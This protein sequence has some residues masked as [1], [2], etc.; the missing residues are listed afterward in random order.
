VCV[1]VCVC[2]AAATAAAAA[3]SDT[4]AINPFRAV[5]VP[6]VA[7]VDVLMDRATNAAWLLGERR[8]TTG[9][10]FGRTAEF[11]VVGLS[12]VTICP[13]I[14]PNDRRVTH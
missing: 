6:F 14:F 8:L 7:L 2:V 12:D 3:G 1:C 10:C 9:A 4:N 13:L 11:G 5:P